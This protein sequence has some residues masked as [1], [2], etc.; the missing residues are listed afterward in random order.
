MNQVLQKY[1]VVKHLT[2]MRQ[3]LANLES[4]EETAPVYDL[5]KVVEALSYLLEKEIM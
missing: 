2:D 1:D 4:I 3:V 5:K